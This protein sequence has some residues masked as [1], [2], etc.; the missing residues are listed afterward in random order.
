VLPKTDIQLIIAFTCLS[1]LL[2]PA[3]AIA[4]NPLLIFSGDLRGEI[5]PCGCA[6]EGDM[7]GLLRRL[8]YIK[9]KHSPH[10]NIL[11]FD[12]GIIFL[13]HLS[14]VILKFH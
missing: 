10:K 1:F 14:K 6:E 13:N 3:A 2:F 11:Y 12:L 4:Q 9:Q 8:T 7:G 5:K